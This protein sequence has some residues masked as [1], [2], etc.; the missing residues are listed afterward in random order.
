MARTNDWIAIKIRSKKTKETMIIYH[1]PAKPSAGLTVD[2]RLRRL[3]QMPYPA[4][5]GNEPDNRVTIEALPG[6]ADWLS[7]KVPASE[8]P[9][10]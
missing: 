10:H 9:K 8:V 4:R 2:V 3:L 5:R 6:G 1:P 7:K